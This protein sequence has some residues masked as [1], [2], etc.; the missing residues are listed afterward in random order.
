VVVTTGLAPLTPTV[1]GVPSAV[2]ARDWTRPQL[3]SL[4]DLACGLVNEPADELARL[5]AGKLL[6]V[7]FYQ[8]STRT[9]LSFETAIRRIGG[10]S[11][12]FADAATTRAGDFFQ[13]TL[14]DTV[15]VVG[16]YADLLVLRHTDDDAGERAAAVAGV[17]VISAGTGER[18]HPTQAMLDTWMLSTAL[19]G[20][21][22]ARI[23]LVGDPG[24]RAIRSMM[25]TLTTMGAAELVLLVPDGCDVTAD[26]RK[27]LAGAG[28]RWREVECAAEM[29][30]GVDAI[31]MIPFELPDFHVPAAAATR[32][33]GLDERFVFSHKLLAARPVPVV[34]T[35][36]RGE[37]L[38]AEVDDL[39]NVYYFY[40]VRHGVTLRAALMARL[41]GRA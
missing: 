18:E 5:A 32:S 33:G 23:G 13:E 8:N 7:L 27:F 20:L 29:V 34:H 14:E 12:G 28:V 10:M 19:G 35:G 9:R 6:G 2:S 16:E 21:D 38:P 17:P 36:P 26:E 22:G 3:E 4:F 25:Y 15:R 11:V 30:A 39:H 1:H 41:L 24:C 31:S 37:E 40:S